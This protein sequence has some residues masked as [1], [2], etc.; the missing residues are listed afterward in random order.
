MLLSTPTT[1][2]Y[3]GGASAGGISTASRHESGLSFGI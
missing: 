3:I 2:H 1:S